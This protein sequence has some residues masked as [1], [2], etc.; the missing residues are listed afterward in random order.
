FSCLSPDHFNQLTRRV[1]AH[2][3]AA[4][5]HFARM[6]RPACGDRDAGE[7]RAL[8][9]HRIGHTEYERFG[10]DFLPL[11][12]VK[13]PAGG[14]AAF[15]GRKKTDLVDDAHAFELVARLGDYSRPAIQVIT[16]REAFLGHERLAFHYRAITVPDP[17]NAH[18]NSTLQPIST[19]SAVRPRNVWK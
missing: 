8:H 4:A 7:H 12:V 1:D 14:D 9:H 11:D 16:R 15:G 2:P 3:V 10:S 19:Q 5:E 13:S 6:R 17:D 18:L